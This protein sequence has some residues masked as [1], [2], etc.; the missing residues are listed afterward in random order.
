[1]RAYLEAVGPLL[2]QY[3]DRGGDRYRVALAVYP[4]P[5][6]DSP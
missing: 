2:R 3:G 6:E 1:M 5:Q 4:H